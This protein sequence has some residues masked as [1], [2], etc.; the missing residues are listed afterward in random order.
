MYIKMKSCLFVCLSEFFSHNAMNSAIEHIS[1]QNFGKMKFSSPEV[2]CCRLLHTSFIL[3]RALK[4]FVYTKENLA[5]YMTK[6]TEKQIR[7]SQSFLA[8]LSI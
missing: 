1:T 4:A 2:C 5:M 3:C 8:A 7:E 6:T